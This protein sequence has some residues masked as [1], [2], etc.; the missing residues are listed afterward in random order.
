MFALLHHAL[1]FGLVLPKI[2]RVYFYLECGELLLGVCD[3]KDSSAPA[4]CVSRARR[5]VA[6]GL[7]YDRPYIDSTRDAEKSKGCGFL[8]GCETWPEAAETAPRERN[9]R[10]LSVA[11]LFFP[12]EESRNTYF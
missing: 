7:Q 11:I 4:R 8:A 6:A 2:G 3:V 10:V 1:R 9:Q 12:S 5:S